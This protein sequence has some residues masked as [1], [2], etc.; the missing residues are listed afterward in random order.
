[1]QRLRREAADFPARLQREVQEA[2]AQ[3]SKEAKQQADQQALLFKKEAESDR[4]VAELQVKT[5][6]DLVA[7]QNAQI[8]D[9]HKQL[10][11]AKRQVQEIAVRAIEGASSAKALA[12]INEI[13]IEQAKHRG[14]QS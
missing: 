2:T 10:D 5:L 4:R 13:A 6:E 9:V 11:E 14:Q 7:R 12:H 1:M 3:A 8:A